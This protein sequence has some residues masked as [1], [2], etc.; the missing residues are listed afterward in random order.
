MGRLCPPQQT[1]CLILPYK[2]AERGSTPRRRTAVH[3]RRNESVSRPRSLTGRAPALQA[4][5]RGSTPCVGTRGGCSSTAERSA[6]DR[7]EVGSA[8][9]SHPRRVR[10]RGRVG[11]GCN[12]VARAEGVRIPPPAPC[13][14]SAAEQSVR[15]RSGRPLVRIQSRVRPVECPSGKGAVRKTAYPGS[16]PGSA[17]TMPSAAGSTQVGPAAQPPLIRADRPVRHRD[18][19]RHVVPMPVVSAS[20]LAMTWGIKQTETG[21]PKTEERSRSARARPVPH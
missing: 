7:E 18:L 19:R 12:P 8:P 14:R 15:L 10:R 20:N 21:A 2:Q 13:P 6:V 11:A 17:S 1:G 3:R 5:G 16:N 4:G 9:T